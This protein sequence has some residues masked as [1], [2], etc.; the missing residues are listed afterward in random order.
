MEEA[1]LRGLPKVELH[2]HLDGSIRVET[3]RELA[4]ARGLDLGAP[5]ADELRRKVTVTRPLKDLA[6]VLKCFDV[7]QKVLFS[8]EAVSRV[9][10]ENIEDAWRDGVKLLELRF[11]PAFIAQG[12]DLSNDEIIAAALDGVGKGME[13]YPI[14]VGL[15][16][17][18]ARSLPL[19]R[20][21]RAARDLIRWHRSGVPNASRIC[22]LDLADGE[23]GVDPRSFVSFVNDAREAGIGI[24]IHSGE[25]TRRGFRVPQFG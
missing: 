5:S 22:G 9:T 25:N 20:N 2:R 12:K 21:A 15:I 3:I 6:A 18:L 14:E 23:E 7:L 11:A 13:A 1:D 8:F 4:D 16:G 10:F 19:E 17:I 24:T